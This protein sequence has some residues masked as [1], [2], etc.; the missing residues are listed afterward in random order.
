M[1]FKVLPRAAPPRVHRSFSATAPPSKIASK[2]AEWSGHG[3]RNS[4]LL[5]GTDRTHLQLAWAMRQGGIGKSAIGVR[6]TGAIP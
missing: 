1:D 4:G 2:M 3:L 6:A 5:K